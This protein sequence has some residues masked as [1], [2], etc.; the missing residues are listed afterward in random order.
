MPKT[1]C[2]AVF[3][4]WFTRKHWVSNGSGSSSY[5]KRTSSLKLRVETH[6]EYRYR[7]A[8]TVVGRVLDELL[9]KTYADLAQ[10]RQV[11]VGLDDLLRSRMR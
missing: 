1:P 9:I 5:S 3:P 6:G 7:P 10:S 11:V 2:P 8:V 4:T